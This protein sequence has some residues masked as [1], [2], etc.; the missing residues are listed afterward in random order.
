[1][2]LG[3]LG[4]EENS[5]NV[6]I[7]KNPSVKKKEDK[8]E[9][10]KIHSNKSSQF[11]HLRQGPFLCRHTENI[12]SALRCIGRNIVPHLAPEHYL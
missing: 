6:K 4:Y 11:K 7:K 2:K 12:E 8:H 9:K 1:M 3:C 10:K 5:A